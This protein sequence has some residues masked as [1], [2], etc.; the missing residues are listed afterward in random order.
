MTELPASDAIDAWGHRLKMIHSSEITARSKRFGACVCIGL[1]VSYLEG[2]SG[3]E[4]AQT[5]L[6]ASVLFLA[7]LLGE[8]AMPKYRSMFKRGKKR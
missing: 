6:L 2:V 8:A 3:L 7:F 1:L 4:I 5:A